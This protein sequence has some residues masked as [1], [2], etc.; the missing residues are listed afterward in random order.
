[1]TT[2]PVSPYCPNGKPHH[3]IVGQHV[4]GI[5]RARCKRCH[6][7]RTYGP[8]EAD[9]QNYGQFNLKDTRHP[10]DVIGHLDGPVLAEEAM[11]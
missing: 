8:V 5:A 6:R 10:L 4:N 1:M 7:A 2:K 9:F 11:R 3:W